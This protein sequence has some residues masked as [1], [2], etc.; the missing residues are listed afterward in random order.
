M[1]DHR[2]TVSAAI[3]A[4]ALV[5]CASPGKVTSTE[6]A[7][8]PPETRA[9]VR[10]NGRGKITS[11]SLTELFT[12][13]QSDQAII[14]DARPRFF[15]NLGHIPGAISLPKDGSEALIHERGDEIK[16]ALAA[17]KTIVV[18]CT[19]FTCPDARTVAIHLSSFGYPSSTLAT[20]W[21]G[22]KE[23]GLPTE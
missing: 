13:Q 7:D 10:L 16:A 17:K 21:D 19:N 20:G 4:V 18:Y 14:F 15:Y 12:L 11:I 2:L 3:F 5:S 9:P 8:T 1:T 6:K 22:W 23:A